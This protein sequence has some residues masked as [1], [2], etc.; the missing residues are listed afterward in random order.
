M[1]SGTRVPLNDY[2]TNLGREEKRF[3]QG[4]KKHFEEVNAHVCLDRADLVIDRMTP[5]RAPEVDSFQQKCGAPTLLG[6]AR[7]CAQR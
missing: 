2:G 5:R 3:L 7:G 4:K 6:D 1:D